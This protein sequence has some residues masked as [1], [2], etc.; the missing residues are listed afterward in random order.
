[1]NIPAS[2]NLLGHTI[3]VKQNSKKVERE[4]D[5]GQ[6]SFTK[7]T[8]KLAGNVGGKPTPQSHLEHTFFHELVHQC[9]WAMQETELNEN[10][11]FVDVMGGLL[12][13]ALGPHM[14]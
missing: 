13:Q 14:K 7:L 11:Q 1:M 3:T 4:K 10:E 9:L 5:F 2:V 6:A 12:H 8:I